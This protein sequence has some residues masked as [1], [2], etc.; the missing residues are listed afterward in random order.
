MKYFS[1]IN[2]I[3]YFVSNAGSQ[4]YYIIKAYVYK[5]ACILLFDVV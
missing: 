2:E 5:N 3:Y 1:L 4:V